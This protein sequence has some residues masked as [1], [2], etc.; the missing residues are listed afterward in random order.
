MVSILLASGFE[1]IEAVVV[2]DVLKRGGVDVTLVSTTGSKMVYGGHK[3]SIETDEKIE[4]I[5][6]KKHELLVIPGGSGGVNRLLQSISVKKLVRKVY[7][8]DKGIVAAICAGP[9]V[10]A[11]A[12]ILEGKDYTCFS[13]VE[14]EINVGNYVDAPVVVSGS[15]ITSQSPSTAMNFAF[16]ILEALKDKDVVKKVYTG[17]TGG[18]T[19]E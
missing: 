2:Y 14:D 11:D 5:M 6:D 16:K 10:L 17:V 7:E 9:L 1:E 8:E 13:G 18:K 15:I 12:D 3:L 19:Y 4:H